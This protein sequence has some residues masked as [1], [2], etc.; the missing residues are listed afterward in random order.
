[1]K[2]GIDSQAPSEAV[3]SLAFRRSSDIAV[4]ICCRVLV[5]MPRKLMVSAST[6]CSVC[7]M[8]SPMPSL[9]SAVLLLEVLDVPP[10]LFS[11]IRNWPSSPVM[12]LI[13]RLGRSG[14]TSRIF[15]TWSTDSLGSSERR[16]ANIGVTKDRKPAK[17][18]RTD[19]PPHKARAHS[20]RRYA[21]QTQGP[22]RRKPSR[23]RTEGRLRR[24][25][26]MINGMGSP[27]PGCLFLD[28]VGFYAAILRSRATAGL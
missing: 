11:C 9:A 5:V 1:M 23:T 14:L 8:T 25:L 17:N 18:A 12:V 16:R 22:S 3:S 4:S 24:T 10:H 21:V 6:A 2:A 28:L 13:S 15:T 27:E 7:E 20:G 19:K 26:A